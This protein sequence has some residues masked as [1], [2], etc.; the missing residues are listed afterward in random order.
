M[1][2]NL[3]QLKTAVFLHWCLICAR[4]F[5]WLVGNGAFLTMILTLGFILFTFVHAKMN[6][7]YVNFCLDLW[8]NLAVKF[9]R[10]FELNLLVLAK[11]CNALSCSQTKS[12]TPHEYRSSGG[13]TW[14]G[15]IFEF[16][17]W[18]R[19]IQS[20]PQIIF[21]AVKA[22]QVGLNEDV[23]MTRWS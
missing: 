22:G 14:F 6:Q 17:K 15:Q 18:F 13:K 7:T 3:W 12:F 16:V 4:P 23:T 5:G 10:F 1:I 19:A 11:F 2:R 8:Q 20:Y 21:L 9:L